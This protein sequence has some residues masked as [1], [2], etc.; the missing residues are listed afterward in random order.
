MLKPTCHPNRPHHARGL[1]SPC[2]N[3]QTR[4]RGEAP[5]ARTVERRDEIALLRKAHAET[6]AARQRLLNELGDAKEQIEALTRLSKRPPAPIVAKKA[7][8]GK[9]RQGVP[10]INLSDWHIEE[11]VYPEQVNGLNHYNLDIAD[12]CITQCTEA[13]EW[14]CRDPRW[15]MRFGV[16]NYMGDLYSGYIHDELVEGNLLSPVESVVWL[17]ARIERQIRTILAHCPFETLIV[18]CEDGNHGRMTHKMRVGTRTANS[19][20]WLLYKSIAA[21][22]ADEKRVRFQIAEGDYNYLSIYDTNVCFFHGDSVKYQGGVGGLLVPLMRGLNEL[23]KYKP[24]DV[25]VLGHFHQYMSLPNVVVNGSMIGT[26]A[27][28][29]RYKFA[30]EPRQQSFFLIDSERGKCVSAPVW[31]PQY[32]GG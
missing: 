28:S 14:F 11:P 10:V 15:D 26:N 12:K 5:A 13:F 4:G 27:Y 29:M 2:Y 30:P 24:A 23:R 17:Q 19:L 22:F 8:R 31:L 21:R 20:E 3:H 16:L 32:G 25:Y 18:M 9:R 1:C 6:E 7:T